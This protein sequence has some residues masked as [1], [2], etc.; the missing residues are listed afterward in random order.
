[1][2]LAAKY[3]VQDCSMGCAVRTKLLWGYLVSSNWPQRFSGDTNT[4]QNW[5]SSAHVR[6]Y[7]PHA[8][9]TTEMTLP[10]SDSKGPGWKSLYGL[11]GVNNDLLYDRVHALHPVPPE[12]CTMRTRCFWM[13][14]HDIT[15]CATSVV[16]HTCTVQLFLMLCDS[17]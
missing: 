9:R 13:T 11:Y 3:K 15:C 12:R 17:S 1:M 7:W 4:A 10:E 6:L 5:R 14:W 2:R 16:K 8:G